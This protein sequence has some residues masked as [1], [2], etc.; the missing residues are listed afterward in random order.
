MTGY[1]KRDFITRLTIFEIRYMNTEKEIN[2][3]F[4]IIV[5]LD[6]ICTKK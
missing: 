4:L 1:K 2:Q 3:R 5:R 6:L